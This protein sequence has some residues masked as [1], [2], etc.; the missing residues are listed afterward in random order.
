M[1]TEQLYAVQN[2]DAL[3]PKEQLLIELAQLRN[4]IELCRR[5]ET[6]HKEDQEQLRETLHSLSVHQEELKTQ[7]E[8]LLALHRQLEESHRKYMELYDFAPIGYFTLDRNGVVL[9]VNLT[10]AEMLDRNK[11][12]LLRKP[13][14]TCLDPESRTVFLAHLRKAF[15]GVEDIIEVEFK[16]DGNRRF[17]AEIKTAPVYG[18]KMNVQS[19]WSVIRDITERKQAENKI[20]D[21]LTEKEVLLR[22]LHHRVKNNMAVIIGLLRLQERAIKNDSMKSVFQ[23]SQTRISSMALIH[24]TL[25]QSKRISEIDLQSY[26]TQLSR[27]LFNVYGISSRRIKLTVQAHDIALNIDQAVPCGLALTELISNSLK[28]AFDEQ[29]EGEIV[30]EGALIGKDD[31]QI[32]VRDSG[33][34]VPENIDISSADTLGLQ[35]VRNLVERQLEGTFNLNRRHGAEFLVTFTKKNNETQ[36]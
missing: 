22:E 4:E 26:I 13:L 16:T 2:S 25:Y 8:E 32:V 7:N 24:E 6:Q 17:P 12:A 10:G 5:K 18:Q 34:G 11:G 27:N 14:L 28:Y 36:K 1:K 15:D 29:S 19:C 31:V 21:S 30:I 33:P 35:L 23:E 3:K 20:R 9:D